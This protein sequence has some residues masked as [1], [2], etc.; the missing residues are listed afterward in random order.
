[1]DITP[2]QHELKCPDCAA[3]MTLE[4]S[5][6]GNRWFYRCERH[7]RCKGCHGAD[8]YGTP[9]GFPADAATRRWRARA[10]KVFN[11]MFPG[12]QNDYLVR[13]AR[14]RAYIWLQFKMNLSIKDCHIANFNIA[15]CNQVITLVKA[16]G[17]PPVIPD[18]DLIEIRAALLATGD[19]QDAFEATYFD[20]EL[21]RR[22][23]PF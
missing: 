12:D 6:Y 22:G 17:R 21:M 1:M 14:K 7:P 23:I 13:G 5:N 8:P 4:P 19:R 9:L 16:L 20:K 15:Q 3:R 18:A 11:H 2:I 10:H